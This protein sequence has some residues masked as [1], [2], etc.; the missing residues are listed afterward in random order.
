MEVSFVSQ[1]SSSLGIMAQREEEEEEDLGSL[2]SFSEEDGDSSNSL[3]SSSSEFTEDATSS[4]S[5]S[6]SSFPPS[7]SVNEMSEEGPLFEMSSLVA[8]LPFKRGLSKHYQG[9]SQSFTSLSNVMSL[10]DLIKPERPIKKK[11]KSSKSYAGGLDN[12]NPLSP[13]HG[14]KTIAKKTLRGSFSSLGGRRHSFMGSKPPVPPQRSE[15]L[16]GRNLLFA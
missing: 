7:S 1:S 3:A 4:N 10:E 15:S 12:H 6:S 9:K 8:E 14:S 11:L 2:S 13:K 16:S 5:S